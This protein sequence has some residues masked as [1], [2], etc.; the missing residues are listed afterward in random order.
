MTW[1]RCEFGLRRLCCTKRQSIISSA[2]TT[3]FS[4][5]ANGNKIK[6][7]HRCSRYRTDR[8]DAWNHIIDISHI[9]CAPIADSNPSSM[10]R[11]RN[12]FEWVF[13]RIQSHHK[14]LKMENVL[15]SQNIA[16]HFATKDSHGADNILKK[17]TKLKPES[18]CF[19]YTLWA[20]WWSERENSIQDT[21]NRLHVVCLVLG[22]FCSRLP[23]PFRGECLLFFCYY[24]TNSNCQMT[25]TRY[26]ITE[27]Y[28]SIEFD[29]VAGMPT[30]RNNAELWRREI[31]MSLGDTGEECNNKVRK[32]CSW[33]SLPFLMLKTFAVVI[34]CTGLIQCYTLSIS[35]Q[36]LTIQVTLF[37][38]RNNNKKIRFVNTMCST[39][40]A[41]LSLHHLYV[42]SGAV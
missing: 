29:A 28:F 6:M 13:I 25:C 39:M 4:L 23:C 7:R 41:P 30:F 31:P 2:K 15:A 8:C 27:K 20:S 37:K 22:G 10:K 5:H 16:V 11:R 17:Q 34:N 38:M 42:E 21:N 24:P 36:A 3:W 14:S 40:C 9:A 19:E 26:Q 32:I 1:T 35:Q 12:R 33:E 18:T